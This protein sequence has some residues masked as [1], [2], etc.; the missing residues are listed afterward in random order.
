MLKLAHA[1]SY[2]DILIKPRLSIVESRSNINLSTNVSKNIKLKIPIVSSNMDTVTEE[3]MAIS[4][5]LI[6][7]IGIIH[8]YNSINEQVQMVKNVKRYINFY[9]SNP[10]TINENEYIQ[11]YY[12]LTDT[13]NF[14]TL[15]V[16]DN[17]YNFKGI[18]NKYNIN[19]NHSL[20]EINDNVI[21][22][23]VMSDKKFYQT[24]QKKHLTRNY[25]KYIKL[26]KEKNVNYLPVLDES[27]VVGL[28][29][30]KDLLFY[31]DKKNKSNLDKD[32]NLVVGAAV[33]VNGDYIE[34][35]RQLINAGVDVLVIDIAHGHSIL[36]P[37]AIQQIKKIKNIDIIAGNVATKEGVK[38]LAEAGADGI[39][40]NIGA[41]SICTTR[42]VTGCGVPQ[43]SAVLE[44]CKE[45]KKYNIPI[46]ADGGHCG[47]TA[48]LVKALSAGA[49]CCM[50][51]KGL[52]GTTESPG[53]IIIK[54]GKK[55]KIIRG[56]A[57]YISNINK[58]K[59]IGTKIKHNFTPEGVEGYIDFKGNVKDV[60][61]QILGGVR[62]GLSYCGV[63]N[64][65][66]LHNTG[67]EYCIITNS[68]IHES[69][70]HGIKT[71]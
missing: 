70:N 20:N 42:I 47:K 35:A 38:F 7:G 40:V 45:A 41:G 49:S 30:L 52:A 64:I 48:S 19:I 6:G 12:D 55:Y 8:R 36:V 59:K 62:S 50:L 16:V 58:D 14:K 67:I 46:I 57:G 51:G 66:D 33:G 17:K 21:V 56:M 4:M 53:R 63:K 44:C 60:I 39:K 24:I 71:L 2:D 26:M 61:N 43:F 65:S 23:D 32:G 3:K 13:E 15:I 28:I 10:I 25:D 31:A 54:N 18:I 9:I 11:K 1:Y 37:P 27:K 69:N 34:R 5:A 68:G 29:T 22:K